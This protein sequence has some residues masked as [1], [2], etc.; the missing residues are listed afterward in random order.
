M[1]RSGFVFTPWMRGGL[2][3]V[4]EYCV[5]LSTAMASPSD[6][7][8]RIVAQH[9]PVRAR[10]DR[11]AV[12]PHVSADEAVDHAVGQV[13]DARAL[14]HDAVL[15]LG[16]LDLHVVADRCE[17][18]DVR[19]HDARAASDDGG[20]ADH[21]ALDHRAFFDHHFSLDTAL[22]IDRA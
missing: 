17:R 1:T 10:L 3:S 20:T 16:I 22:G 6:A 7:D 12:N 21:G 15:D 13:A 2:A 5:G 19:V 8:L 18:A 14:E 9:E 11:F 4:A